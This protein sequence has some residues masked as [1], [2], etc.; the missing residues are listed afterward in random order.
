MDYSYVE[1]YY[2]SSPSLQ[3]AET[4]QSSAKESRCPPAIN[5]TFQTY[6]LQHT[7]SAASSEC[8]WP[9]PSATSCEEPEDYTYH[10][11][12]TSASCA[13]AVAT[14]SARSSATSPRSWSSPEPQQLELQQEA[15]KRQDQLATTYNMNIC[16]APPCEERFHQQ[17]PASPY[18]NTAYFGGV[19]PEFPVNE[20]AANMT[21]DR[22]EPCTSPHCDSPGV[23][24]E[25]GIMCCVDHPQQPNEGD[26][27]Y[28]GDMDYEGDDADKV[29]PPYAQLIY[30]AFMSKERHAMTLQEI[31]QW[32]RDNTEKA[33]SETKGWQNSIRHNLSMNAVSLVHHQLLICVNHAAY[34]LFYVMTDLQ[35]GFRQRRR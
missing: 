24:D 27:K 34:W 8:M 14:R 31:Y 7:P 12:P 3:L 11:S 20:E 29:D 32:F 26:M 1:N 6:P 30:Q 9:T 15:W 19:D 5:T 2:T 18:A 35:A 25:Y 22:A 17:V 4:V 23:K 33:N 28:E 10:G 13:V 21:L 16:V